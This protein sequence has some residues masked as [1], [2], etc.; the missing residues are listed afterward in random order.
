MSTNPEDDPR[1]LVSQ[2]GEPARWERAWSTLARPDP[3]VSEA[4]CEGLC[5]GRWVVRR[6]CA[7]WI[8]T[9]G[10]REALE[11]VLPLIRDPHGKVRAAAAS[12]IGRPRGAVLSDALPLLIERIR[13]D[14]SLR[15][16][17]RC[18]MLL[19]YGHAH[20]QLAPFFQEL[21]DTET[22]PKLHRFAGI[23]LVLS[24]AERQAGDSPGD[25]PC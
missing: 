13:E 21:L 3:D 16:R 23:G 1:E 4:V 5:D 24:S 11:L 2:L 22:D 12:V 8:G 7:W 25:S 18:V 9:H 6:W 14:E 17:R 15:V 10:D 19:A 20:P